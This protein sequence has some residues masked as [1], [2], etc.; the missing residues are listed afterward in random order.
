MTTVMGV[1]LILMFGVL[2]LS[3]VG[4]LLSIASNTQV[5][6]PPSIMFDRFI[7]DVTIFDSDGHRLSDGA[8][9]DTQLRRFSVWA[10]GQVPDPS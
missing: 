5:L 2:L 7:A 3:L 10:S 1:S 8:A 9:A 6:L 4:L